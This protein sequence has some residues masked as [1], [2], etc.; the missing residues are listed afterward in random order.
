MQCEVQYC[1]ACVLFC[2]F[3]YVYVLNIVFTSH[4]HSQCSRFNLEQPA[5]VYAFWY[6]V[7]VARTSSYQLFLVAV[8]VL[9]FGTLRSV[10]FD[11]HCRHTCDLSVKCW[12]MDVT[13]VSVYVIRTLI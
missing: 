1:T 4:L 2:M 5:L 13:Y 6:T 7:I 10:Q 9:G 11:I 12:C 8:V 3:L